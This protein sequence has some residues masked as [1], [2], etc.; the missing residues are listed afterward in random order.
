VWQFP[1]SGG[2]WPQFAPDLRLIFQ[3]KYAI[4]YLPRQVEIVIVRVFDGSR[5]IEAIAEEEGFEL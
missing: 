5:D 4:N 1:L 3:N 2:S